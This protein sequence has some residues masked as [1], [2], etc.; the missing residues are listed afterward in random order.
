[1]AEIRGT[2]AGRIHPDVHQRA[3]RW[4]MPFDFW[5]AELIVLWKGAR[6]GDERIALRLMRPVRQIVEFDPLRPN[7]RRS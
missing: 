3:E 1:M 6:V 7:G 5:E 4:W 2:V